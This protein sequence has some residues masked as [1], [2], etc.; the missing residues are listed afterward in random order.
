MAIKLYNV[1]DHEIVRDQLI[2]NTV[3]TAV[4]TVVLVLRFISR[5]IRESKLWWD[6]AFCVLSMVGESVS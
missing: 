1:F 6:D 3:L 5:R 2:A 4:S